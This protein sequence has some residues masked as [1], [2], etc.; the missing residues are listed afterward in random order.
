MKVTLKELPD[1]EVAFFRRIGSYF[2][3]TDDHWGK[4][5]NWAIRNELYPP[6]QNFIGISL[7][8]PELVDSQQCRHDACVTIPQGFGK[9]QSKENGIQ[10]KKLDGG[11]YALNQ[12]YDTPEKLNLAYKYMYEEWL[13]NS[14]YDTDF[15]R[16]NLEFSM[17]NPAED[18]EGKCRVDLFVPIKKRVS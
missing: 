16:Y 3:A 12:F 1:Y 13:P 4:L 18:P 6:K 2:E 10:F 8:N 17:N 14:E 9:D 11:L 15:D 5:I 7:D